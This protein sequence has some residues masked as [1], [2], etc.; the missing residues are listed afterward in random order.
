MRP[1]LIIAVAVLASVVAGILW[2]QFGAP[3]ASAQGGGPPGGMALAVEAI[4]LKP[5]PLASGLTTVGSLRAG[6]SVVVR[7]EISGRLVRIGFADGAAVAQGALLFELDGAVL[8]AEVNEAQ[9]NLD[10]DR[11]AAN[12]ARE[13]A[14]KNLVAHADHDAAQAQQAISAARLASAQAQLA[15]TRLRA[16]FAGVLGLREVSVGEVLSPGQALVSLVRLDPMQVDFGLPESALSAVAVGEPVT[17]QVDTFPDE[18]FS[19]TVLAI[20][21][22]VDRDSRAIRVRASIGNGQQRLRPGQFARVQIGAASAAALLLPEQAL[23]QDG[24]TRFVYRIVDG[25]AV[26]TVIRTGRR[27]PGQVQVLAG[28]KAGDRVITAGQGK[29]MMHDGAAVSVQAEPSQEAVN[30]TDVAADEGRG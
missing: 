26:R 17:V 12:R 25:K 1:R 14:A 29:P 11:R 4:T 22:A 27:L 10:N 3:P 18:A 23:L 5:R 30:Q 20:E 7:P 15:Q 2:R 21:P 8:R 28:L 6:E 19:G 9:A 24:D 13:L 16:P